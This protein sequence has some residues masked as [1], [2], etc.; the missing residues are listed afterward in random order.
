M[1]INA[2]NALKVDLH[3]K[4]SGQIKTTCPLCS[5]D[6]KKKGDRCLSVNIDTGT[7]YCHHCGKTGNIHTYAGLPER[8]HQYSKPQ[9]KLGIGLNE[10]TIRY[11]ENR[12][13]SKS[14]L[15]KMKITDGEEY[16]PQVKGKR[17][18]I[19]FGY[20]EQGELVNIKYRD[21]KK[22]FKMFKD[23][24][25]TWYNIDS[26]TD[27][28]IIVE[29]EMDALSFIE[30]GIDS[31]VS[32]PNGAKNC[33]FF[34]PDFFLNRQV[35]IAVDNDTAGN[36]LKRELIRRIG[37]ERCKIVD[38]LGCK[39]ANE[40]LVK[41]GSE[42]LKLVADLAKEIPMEGIIYID[43][44]FD[45]LQVIFQNGPPA[46]KKT[47]HDKLNELITWET[48]RL[49]IITGIP[50]HGK[51]EFVDEIS[52]NLNTLYGWRVGFFSPENWPISY[53]VHKLM[54]KVVG[55]WSNQIIYDAWVNTL[56]YMRENY[57]WIKPDNEDYSLE[58]IL[59]KGRYLVKRL[60][61]KVLV[62]DPWNYIE[63]Q[64]DGMT[65]TQY[66]SK[67]LTR[68][69]LFARQN[70]VLVMLV[71]HPRKMEKEK[72]GDAWVY[73]VPNLYSISGSAHFFNKADYGICVYRNQD[74]DE[75]TI[76]V[77]KVKFRHLGGTGNVK[78]RN[79]PANGRYQEKP[80]SGLMK[81]DEQNYCPEQVQPE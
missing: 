38:F 71:A 18:T 55:K 33:D 60:G 23:G 24:K 14:V 26:V 11:F 79:N 49:A 12:G 30:A 28:V 50:G 56:L 29:G 51:S 58:N 48:G 72:V 36:E 65:E 59:D 57:F 16:M 27:R 8:P 31:V 45:E 9:V 68:I 42:A 19:Q 52:V 35:V 61:L 75:V 37:A 6:R 3:G 13:I 70:E 69:S 62:I 15:E 54:A 4:S 67:M 40:Y 2:F 34:D 78:M 64:L 77:Q 10:K 80:D 66:I 22:N 43:D 46:G 81:W 63:H 7:Y 32:V 47:R 20:Y 44:I 73:E 5:A 25:L 74:D 39:D 21:D 17:H 53:H 1:F 41:H 76:H